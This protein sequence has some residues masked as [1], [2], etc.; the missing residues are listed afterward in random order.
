MTVEEARALL[1]LAYAGTP[2]L[3]DDFK[4]LVADLVF[5]P[6][7]AKKPWWSIKRSASPRS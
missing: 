1:V 7:Q 4:R 5:P 2:E 6:V 3:P